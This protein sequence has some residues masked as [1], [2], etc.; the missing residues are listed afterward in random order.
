MCHLIYNLI[1]QLSKYKYKIKVTHKES[2]VKCNEKYDEKLNC[3][4]RYFISKSLEPSNYNFLSW[5]SDVR[6]Y[7]SE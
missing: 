2:E 4:L 7:R 6:M 3:V 5:D 1:F